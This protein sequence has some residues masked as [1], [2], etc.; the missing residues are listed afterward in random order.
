MKK[1]WF[2]LAAVVLTVPSFA[3][4]GDDEDEGTAVKTKRNAFFLGPKIGGTLTSLRESGDEKMAD[5]SGFGFSG[6]IAFQA[7]FGKA[8]A[9]SVG[10]TG[11]W[12][13]GIELKYKQNRVKTLAF[14]DDGEENASL[15]LGYLEI[16]VYFHVYPF[17]RISSLNSL[18]IEAGV[19]FAPLITRSPKSLDLPYPSQD[20]S[21]KTY[22]LDSDAGKLKGGDIRPIVGLGYVIPKTGLDINVRYYIGTSDLAGNMPYKMNSFE[23]SLAWMFNLGKF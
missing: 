23:F 21:W 13:A 12:S 10:G 19:S 17:A 7:R 15:S 3:Q 6:G 1:F 20:V 14:G 5:G 16:P 11:Y 2:L 8:S 22:Y 4:S 9:N 18:Y